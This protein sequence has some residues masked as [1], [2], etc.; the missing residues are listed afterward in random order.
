MSQSTL[1]SHI[2]TH[3]GEKKFLCKHC[4]KAFLN[5]GQLK[6]HERCH[7][8]EKPFKCNVSAFNLFRKFMKKINLYLN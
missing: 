3:T 6:N 2:A 7:T 8:G 5:S 4:G 1:T